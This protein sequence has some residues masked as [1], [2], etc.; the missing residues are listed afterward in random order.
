[1]TIRK[2]FKAETLE[3][4]QIDLL[5][6]PRLTSAKIDGIR[7]LVHPTIGPV[8]QSFNPVPNKHIRG[9][10]AHEALQGFDGEICVLTIMGEID[11]YNTTQSG[12]M[13]FEGTPSFIFFVFDDMTEPEMPYARR[14]EILQERINAMPPHLRMYVQLLEHRMTRTP[15]ELKAYYE[16]CLEAGHEGIVT[17]TLGSP[18]KSGRSTFIQSWMLKW[19][20]WRDAEGI[21]LRF[22]EQ[23]ENTNEQTTNL[24]GASVRSSHQAGMLGKNTLG[25]FI[26]DTKEWGEVRVG[27]GKGMTD[28]FRQEVWDNQEEYRGRQMVYRYMYYGMKNKPRFPKYKGWR[29]D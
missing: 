6:Y 10:L 3:E 8:T 2:P 19:K 1:M 16:E 27:G 4:H 18:Y 25:A 5:P 29:K 17:R 26:I 23:V 7:G 15:E 24:L 28:A 12:V 11:E 14:Y 9:I 20:P 21:V 22:E 13:T